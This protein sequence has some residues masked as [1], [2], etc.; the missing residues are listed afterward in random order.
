M[1]DAILKKRELFTVNIRKER[2]EEE[3]KIKRKVQTKDD[4]LLNYF[5]S[6]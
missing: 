4:Q 3:F 6:C 5:R 2:R 1:H